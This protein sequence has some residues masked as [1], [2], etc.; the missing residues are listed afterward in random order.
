MGPENGYSPFE[1]VI[2]YC[3]ESESLMANCLMFQL[4]LHP[5]YKERFETYYAEAL[6]L[7]C[8]DVCDRI[9]MSKD[10]TLIAG[11]LLASIGVWSL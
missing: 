11:I 4:S 10:A 2:S 6:R 3:D 1:A 5:E 9:N 7:F 8:R